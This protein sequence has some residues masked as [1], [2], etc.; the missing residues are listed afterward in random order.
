[1]T[2]ILSLALN[3]AIDV[4]S[5]A[6]AVRTT[7]KVRTSN[8]SYDPGGGGVNVARVI[9][10]LGGDVELL[11]LAG[12][13]MGAFLD[14][15]LGRDG[16]RRR[17]I[18]IAGNTRISFTVVERPT[19]QE[20][21]F[22]A[23]GPTLQPSELE[24][25]LE[26]VRTSDFQ[27]CVASGSLPLGAPPDFL[28]RIARIV[29]AKG[30]RFVLDSSGIGLK[31]AL[32]QSSAYLVK[33]SLNELEVLAGQKLDERGARAKAMDLV[34]RGA[35]EMVA[36]TLGEGGAILATRDGVLQRPALKVDVRSSVGAGDSFLAAMTLALAD[37]RS[38]ADAL[39]FGVA[40]GAAALLRPGTKLCSRESFLRLYAEAANGPGVV[41]DFVGGERPD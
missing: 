19:G 26:A 21:R 29:A 5:E 7:H 36:V 34:R 16:V 9:T 6:E 20:Y 22:V 33:P 24:A 35:A 12:G 40:A 37:G 14:E 38:P 23:A 4:S 10:E 41:T 27:W 30:A 32:D 11:F 25:C 13:V 8:E 17:M 1:M 15:L 39:T 28:A 31:T 3:P 2:R 18:P